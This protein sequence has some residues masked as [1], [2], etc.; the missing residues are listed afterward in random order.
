MRTSPFILV[1]GVLLTACTDGAYSTVTT[2]GTTTAGVTATGTGGAGGA[3][4]AGGNVTTTGSGGAGGSST[5]TG[6]GGAGGSSTTTGAGGAGGSVTTTGAGGTGGNVTTTSTSD[7]PA[8]LLRPTLQ[9]RAGYDPDGYGPGVGAPFGTSPDYPGNHHG[10]DYF[11]LAA[12][13][14]QKLGIS[15]AESKVIYPVVDGGAHRITSPALGN[16]YWQALDGSTRAYYWHLSTFTAVDG[17]MVTVTTPL[18][19]MGHTGTAAGSADH[20][21]FEIRLA[22]YSDGNRVDPEPYFSVLSNAQKDRYRKIAAFLNTY[23]SELAVSKTTTD[24]D[25]IPGPNYWRLVQAFGK[26]GGFY[27][28]TVDGIPGPLTYAAENYIWETYVKP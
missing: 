16:G 2:P 27:S 13:S 22:P 12:A 18:G 17:A 14:A 9:G 5:T 1:V 24:Q 26:K 19:V 20:L 28:G 25:G 8:P 7:E 23:A 21:H 11:W 6:S 15:T 3:G 10:Q 4:G